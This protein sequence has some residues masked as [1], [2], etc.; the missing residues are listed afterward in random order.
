MRKYI[1]SNLIIVIENLYNNAVFSNNNIGDCFRTSVGVRQGCLLSLTLF[2]I[3]LERIMTDALEDHFGTVS[4]GDRPITKLRF[5]DDIDGVARNVCELASLVEKL[6]KASSNY[7]MEI[8]AEKT[9]IMTDDKESS[10]KEI[11]VN[12]QKLES[13]SKFKDLGSKITDEG[14]KPEILSRISQTT[15]KLKPIW[16]NK[17]I[18]ISS[19][20]R[21]LHS[22]VMS[23]FLYA[24]ESWTLNA[25]TERKIRAMKMG[26]YKRLL[27]VSHKEHITNEE[28]RRRIENVIAPRVD[29]LTIVR[30]R[31]LKS[32]GHTTRSSGLTK[33]IMQGRGGLQCPF[34][35]FVISAK[36]SCLCLNHWTPLGST[37]H[38]EQPTANLVSLSSTTKHPPAVNMVY[39]S[40]SLTFCF[41]LVF[42]LYFSLAGAK[43][44]QSDDGPRRY[45]HYK[46]VR[47]FSNVS[48]TCDHPSLN[49]SSASNVRDVSWVLPD[50]TNVDSNEDVNNKLF[51]FSNHTYD[52][53]KTLDLYNLT[54]KKI[55][56]DMFGYYHCVVQYTTSEVAVIRWGLNVNGA[57]F[58]DLLDDYRENAVIGGIAAAS[59]L[60]VIGGC[61]LFWNSRY[62]KRQEEREDE[63]VHTK[64]AKTDT[65]VVV[66][67]RDDTERKFNNAAYK[68]DVDDEA[69]I[70]VHM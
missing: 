64:D 49:V 31:K 61:C 32:Y 36:T 20:I 33:T 38:T 35:I 66:S 25:D 37:F 40:L 14:S 11:K 1:Y 43:E 3:F 12:S 5:A 70:D 23:I 41:A 30:K 10:K 55:D 46:T 8:S 28:V 59:V 7:G 22:L 47:F 29:L 65:M 19:K 17:N 57:D 9:K 18:A 62:S 53:G 48:M 39:T 24:C 34:Y 67:V 51:S 26:C 52:S 54:A 45:L 50:G 13:V 6:D 58:S 60:L 15:T 42:S 68:E 2:N 56:D 44:R 16:N 63:D 21:L 4:I 27:S 69:T